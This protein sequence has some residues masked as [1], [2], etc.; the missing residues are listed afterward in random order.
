MEE[1]DLIYFASRKRGIKNFVE[2]NSPGTGKKFKL[3][4][5][6][7]EKGSGIEVAKKSVSVAR[8]TGLLVGS[9]L[10]LLMLLICIE[11]YNFASNMLLQKNI[12]QME[13][14]VLNMEVMVLHCYDSIDMEGKDSPLK[15][16]LAALKSCLEP[17][18]REASLKTEEISLG[19]LISGG[20]D[21]ESIF[22]GNNSNPCPDPGKVLSLLGEKNEN[23]FF[24]DGTDGEVFFI[25]R[26]VRFSGEE[27]GLVWATLPF[28][29]YQQKLWNNLMCFLVF[30]VFIIII[31]LIFTFYISFWI[32]KIAENFDKRVDAF[33]A[34]PAA[35]EVHGP[36]SQ[37]VP[38]EFMPLL[39]KHNKMALYIQDLLK[40]LSISVRTLALGEMATAVVHDVKNPLTVIKTSAE[41]IKNSGV[42]K[43]KFGY[44]RRIMKS[45]QHI[46]NML[47]RLLLLV[48]ESESERVYISV[49]GL[50]QDL[51]FLYSPLAK[52]Q[53]ISMEIE[54][55]QG[56]PDIFADNVSLRQALMNLII[57]ALEATQVGGTIKINASREGSW[58]KIC[59]TDTGRGI[60]ED[61]QDKV[62]QKFFT[63]KGLQGTGIG[64]A[65]A[66][67][68][69]S[70]HGGKI[71]L[72]SEPGK[73]TTFY[74]LLPLND[75][76]AT[77]FSPQKR[78]V[79]EH[80]ADFKI[81]L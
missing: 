81:S 40:Q 45:C 42:E 55:E 69:I 17:L 65:L 11:R 46:D 53:D 59:L 48:K 12:S 28:T 77:D 47:E 66:N 22:Y 33:R 26:L 49:E 16:R 74:V 24:K 1:K 60:P 8:R 73:G 36:L 27:A 15:E 75:L 10:V 62:F 38:Q 37:E 4:S 44:I 71:W 18:Y 30:A 61:Y 64:L 2:G 52:K 9:F 39:H 58:I 5:K 72:E 54:I 21:S 43:K 67:T 76:K 6:Y 35:Y 68:V 23:S 70:N 79:K 32:R 14:I 31:S 25:S 63:T 7:S 3:I 29:S 51:Y 56:L 80:K 41:L 20:M 34:N 19:F 50:L 13:V 57:N 78:D